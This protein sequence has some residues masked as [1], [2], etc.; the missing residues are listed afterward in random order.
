MENRGLA[1]GINYVGLTMIM[2]RIIKMPWRGARKARRAATCVCVSTPSHHGEMDL[3]K[4]SF[5]ETRNTMAWHGRASP[6]GTESAQE[7][8]PHSQ[9]KFR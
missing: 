2:M 1:P 3:N 9:I 5:T 8:I 7:E 4:R 6:R